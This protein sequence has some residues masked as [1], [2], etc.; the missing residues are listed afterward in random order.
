MD[1]RSSR[2]YIMTVVG[3]LAALIMMVTFN[4]LS[5][6]FNAV[7]DLERARASAE[8]SAAEKRHQSRRRPISV[9][10]VGR[11]IVQQTGRLPRP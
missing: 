10:N 9:D 6:Y 5:F 7:N 2:M 1:K 11:E 4:Y 3:I 8:K